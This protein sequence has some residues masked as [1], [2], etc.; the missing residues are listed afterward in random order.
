LVFSAG[1]D[2]VFVIAWRARD[3]RFYRIIEC[4]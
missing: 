1:G 4:C 2:S 3:G